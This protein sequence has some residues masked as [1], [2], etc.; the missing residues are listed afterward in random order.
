MM[1]GMATFQRP[2]PRTALI[3]SSIIGVAVVARYWVYQQ[4]RSALHTADE[5]SKQKLQAALDD[6]ERRRRPTLDWDRVMKGVLEEEARIAKEE[7]R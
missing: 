6:E 3:V 7:T 2:K 1:R 5:M 4:S